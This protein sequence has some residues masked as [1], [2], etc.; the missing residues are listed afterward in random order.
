MILVL[1]PFSQPSKSSP[2]PLSASKLNQEIEEFEDEPDLPQPRLS[3]AIDDEGTENDSFEDVPPRLSMPPEDGE[4]TGVSIEMYRR[5]VDHRPTR[6]LS[7]GTFQSLWESDQFSK[8]SELDPR[9]ELQPRYDE[10]LQQP[11]LGILENAHGVKVA[12]LPRHRF[13]TFLGR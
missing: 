7:I 8:V 13:V 4:Q 10:P 9:D 5:A 11:S 12:N 3:V 2:H 6:S 1:A